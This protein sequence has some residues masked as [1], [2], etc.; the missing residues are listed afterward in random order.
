MTECLTQQ[1]GVQ[2]P[3]V[4]DLDS[5]DL[6]ALHQLTE[7]GFDKVTGPA[8]LVTAL[9]PGVRLL[10]LE[11]D[12]QGQALAAQLLGQGWRPIVAVAQQYALGADGQFWDHRQVMHIGGAMLKPVISPG[13]LRRKC[14]RKP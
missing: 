7:H 14:T 12:Q 2:M 11:G 1:P 10:R 13:Q 4:L 9:R 5:P 8:E 3:K 6:K